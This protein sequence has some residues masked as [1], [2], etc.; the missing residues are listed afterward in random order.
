MRR[1]LRIGEAA[2]LLGVSTKTIRH[3]QKIG[4]LPEPARSEGGYRLY[5]GEDLLR[6]L[7]IRRLT[8]LGLPLAQVRS[9]LAKPGDRE[10]LRRALVGLR[11]RLSAEIERLSL[12]RA[13]IDRLLAEEEG[14]GLEE[15]GRPPADVDAAL[16]RLREQLADAVDA[17][18]IDG[19]DGAVLDR[20]FDLDRRML[21]LLYELELP[22]GTAERLRQTLSRLAADPSPLAAL[23]PLLAR[24][25][26]LGD[27]SEDAPE[28]AALAADFAAAIPRDL[29]PGPALGASPFAGILGE[30]THGTLSPA[31]SRMLAL[32][33]ERLSP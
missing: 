6:L 8:A 3:Y 4:L 33:Q 25:T 22:D 29:A 10:P 16:S 9:L 21:G 14:T 31:Q 24:W 11:E 32:L 26:A 18:H 7:R 20:A 27:L 17:A 13:E 23:L 2:Q 12:R 1:Y 30:V 28:V 15:P 5:A 19:L